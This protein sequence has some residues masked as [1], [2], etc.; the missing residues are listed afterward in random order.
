[1]VRWPGRPRRTPQPPPVPAA[2]CQFLCTTSDISD[3]TT[4]RH[5]CSFGPVKPTQQEINRCSTTA[6]CRRIM[7][8][9]HGDARYHMIVTWR[10]KEQD[11]AAGP[12]QGAAR[13]QRR[14]LQG[15][16]HRL[17]Q[18][19]LGPRQ[20]AHITEP[21]ARVLRLDHLCKVWRESQASGFEYRGWVPLGFPIAEMQSG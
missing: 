16:L 4:T 17:P 5:V 2:S 21:R 19:R 11:A 18:R 14:V 8:P 12:R 13:K 20:R 7:M 15:Q 6:C 9:L 1:M 10:A 3:A